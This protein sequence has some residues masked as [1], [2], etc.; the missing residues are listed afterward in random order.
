MYYNY[1]YIINLKCKSDVMRK[2]IFELL[3]NKEDEKLYIDRQ[4][5]RIKEL[6]QEK[7]FT[8][9]KSTKTI[10]E[11]I[12]ENYFLKWKYRGLC[13]NIADFSFA[14]NIPGLVDYDYIEELDEVLLYQEFILNIIILVEKNRSLGKTIKL[15]KDCIE[16]FLDEYNY[17]VIEAIDKRIIVP[18]SEIITRVAEINKDLTSRIVEYNSISLKGNIHRKKELI[19]S[20]AHK[21]EGIENK[22]KTGGYSSIVNHLSSVLNNLDI[23]HNNVIGKKSN[24]IMKNMPSK[25][26]ELW[27]DKAYDTLLLALMTSH[28]LE[29]KDDFDKFNLLLKKDVNEHMV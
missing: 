16:K 2:N 17:K 3:N 6:F 5:S 22:L 18:K 20:I 24:E 10:Y 14:N 29:Y 11:Y 25:E 21:Y 19:L 15:I 8:L 28:Y 1:D 26:L 4:F 23:R 27:Y 12:D 13:I 9:G 7:K